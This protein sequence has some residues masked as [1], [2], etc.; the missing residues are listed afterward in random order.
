MYRLWTHSN[1]AVCNRYS[2]RRQDLKIPISFKQLCR[3]I[4]QR[5]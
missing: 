1:R 5:L 3:W 2:F 4:R